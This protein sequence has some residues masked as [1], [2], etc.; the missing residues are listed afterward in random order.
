M[1]ALITN[2]VSYPAH[3]VDIQIIILL[4]C[5]YKW[6]TTTSTYNCINVVRKSVVVI[7]KLVIGECLLMVIV[8]SNRYSS[9]KD[10]LCGM[11]YHY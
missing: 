8:V 4:T 9:T 3:I 2:T 10:V 5:S 11:H 7:L 6:E 1:I